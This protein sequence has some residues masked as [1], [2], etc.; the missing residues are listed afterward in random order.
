[1]WYKSSDHRICIDNSVNYDI[2][3]LMTVHS[4]GRDTRLCAGS[5]HVC[6]QCAWTSRIQF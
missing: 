6:R 4:Q 3:L 1:M 2:Y 5:A